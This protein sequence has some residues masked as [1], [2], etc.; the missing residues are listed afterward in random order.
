MQF[1]KGK[2]LHLGKNKSLHQYVE[3]AVQLESTLAEKDLVDAKLNMNQQSVPVAK[4]VN[5]LH[6]TQECQRDEGSDPSPALGT[7]E[8]APGILC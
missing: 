4:A 3:G 1:N 5:G 6:M 7:G 2:I 8:A